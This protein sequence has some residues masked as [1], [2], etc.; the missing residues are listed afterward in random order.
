MQSF[1]NYCCLSLHL[2]VSQPCI[3][4]LQSTKSPFRT[5]IRA[6]GCSL[7]RRT[8]GL[9]FQH[10]STGARLKNCTPAVVIF[11]PSSLKISSAWSLIALSIRIFKL[12]VAIQNTSIQVWYTQ[13]CGSNVCLMS[14][15]CHY[16]RYINYAKMHQNPS[17]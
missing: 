4:Q 1:F 3:R 8:S 12:V 6:A 9:S 15:H 16:I 11:R 7:R 13:M 17:A 2:R 14:T 10:E 5:S